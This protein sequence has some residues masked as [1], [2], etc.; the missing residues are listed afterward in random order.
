[1]RLAL[2]AAPAGSVR[3]VPGSPLDFQGVSVSIG[4]DL[5]IRSN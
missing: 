5:L 2:Q 3:V 4:Q 1:M